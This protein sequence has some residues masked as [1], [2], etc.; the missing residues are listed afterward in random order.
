MKI[1]LKSILLSVVAFTLSLGY[2]PQV[3]IPAIPVQ[4]FRL[5]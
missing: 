3:R 4:Q 1:F 2:A 5:Y